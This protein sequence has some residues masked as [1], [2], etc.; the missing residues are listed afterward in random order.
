MPVAEV[1]GV[2]SAIITIIEASI[3]IYRTAS[4]AS[5]LPQSFRD[6]ASRLPLVQDTLKLA[7]DGLA[8]EALDAESQ[9]SLGA[10][11]EKCTDRA[12][13]LLEIFQTVITPTGASRTE[14][15]L[16]ALKT[17][18]QAEKVE[19]LMEGIMADLQLV[20]TNHAVKA[21]T[22]KQMETL[23]NRIEIDDEPC[24]SPIILNNSGSG[25]QFVH[26]G[27]GHQN[28]ASGAAT[29]INGSFNGGTFSFYQ[30]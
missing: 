23:M 15:Y 5:G 25:R 21:A 1:T 14:K 13:E 6:A 2:I 28:I 24:P 4:E 20:A 27:I 16:R 29:Q 3:K 11:L 7:V 17:I 19:T 8:E 9:A 12:A 30:K 18:P 10:V 22:R 26:S